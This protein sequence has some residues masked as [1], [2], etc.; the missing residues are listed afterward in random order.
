MFSYHLTFSIRFY[1]LIV[2]N[3]YLFWE[4]RFKWYIGGKSLRYI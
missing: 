1:N 2:V 3:Y 4:R